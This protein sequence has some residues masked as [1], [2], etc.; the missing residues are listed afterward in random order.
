MT[1]RLDL[2]QRYRRI[3]EGLLREH[4][5]K[6]EVWA[7]GSRITG[8]SHEGS[9]LDL[10]V[11]GPEL[12]PLGDGFFELLEAIEKSNIPILIQAHDWAR[13]PESF[14]AEIERDYVVLQ[15]TGEKKMTA[16]EWREM[17]FN[18]FLLEPVRNGIYKRK[19]FH[20]R[21][22]KIV[23]MGELFAH[24]RLRNMQMKRVELTEQEKHRASVVQD[25]LL[26]ARRS[27]VAEGAG[28]CCVVLET[29]EPTSFESSIIRARPDPNKADSLFLYYYFNSPRGLHALDS[30]RRQVAVA[31]I[32]GTDLAQLGILAPP[33][34]EQ[35]AIAHVLGTLDDKIELN[36]RMNETLEEMARALFK[37]WFV[38]FDP[39]RAMAALKQHA[40]S[41]SHTHPAQRGADGEK[42]PGWTIERARA[43]LDNMDPSIAALFPDRFVDTEL[44]EIPEGWEV[45]SLDDSLGLLSGGTPKTT[46]P[47]YWNGNIP[48]YTA[49]DAPTES[50]VFVIDTERKI[51]EAGVENSATKIIAAGTTIITARGTVGRLACLGVPMAMNQ[52]CYGIQ[53]ADG[54]PK[55][56]TYWNLRTVIDELLMRTHGTI[57]D[58]ITRKTFTLIDVPTIPTGLTRAFEAVVDPIMSCIL[59]NLLES[60]SLT[61]QRDALLPKLVS[62][63][64]TRLST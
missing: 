45:G 16:G 33:I 15:E 19:E 4:V 36:R 24:P 1:D 37:S 56:F 13:L 40:T 34:S 6:A 17:P 25:D 51:T 11:R 12:K 55:Y 3:L 35:R 26:F 43:Y 9:D 18:E 48:W 42:S 50:D 23:N 53:G 32:T 10:V 28:K 64:I 21:G 47:A 46:E 62:G 54:Y 20:G 57:F 39:V 59:N 49:R 31:G 38:D 5:P 52:T 63:E 61:H 22:V 29:D 30:I 27:L 60:R 44:G 58:T 7:Y 14:H 41:G 8:E 2:P